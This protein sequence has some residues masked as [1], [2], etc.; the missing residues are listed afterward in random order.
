MC[1]PCLG[2]NAL[3]R[4]PFNDSAS[5]FHF[6]A[7]LGTTSLETPLDNT[8]V[9]HISFYQTK[10]PKI[11]LHAITFPFFGGGAMRG[12]FG[13]TPARSPSWVS[14]GSR[15]GE[16]RSPLPATRQ[17]GREGSLSLSSSSCVRIQRKCAVNLLGVWD[18]LAVR[19]WL[20]LLL[21]STASCVV[22]STR[23]GVSNEGSFL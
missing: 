7:R 11:V 22:T 10:P 15:R 12:S 1:L 20:I 18:Q 5:I 21:F 23:K 16:D 19:D 4:N 9:H 8:R 14:G 13:R 17:L 3:S 2:R 6:L